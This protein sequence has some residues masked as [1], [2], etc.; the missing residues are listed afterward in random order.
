MFFY[1]VILSFL[2]CTLHV[3]IGQY[4]EETQD[5]EK[6]E[7]VLIQLSKAKSLI[8]T[9]SY[10]EAIKNIE[11]SYYN[12]YN[13][14][15]DKTRVSYAAGL[16]KH[17]EYFA[18]YQ[19]SQA[20]YA[21]SYLKFIQASL[22]RYQNDSTNPDEL[23]ELKTKMI[24]ISKLYNEIITKVI[25]IL[26]NKEYVPPKW[27]VMTSLCVYFVMNTDNENE[28]E[29]KATI[30]AFL[31]ESTSKVFTDTSDNV[32]TCNNKFKYD[33]KWDVSDELEPKLEKLKNSI[34][35]YSAVLPYTG[36]ESVEP[37]AWVLKAMV[38][39][40]QY[41]K[42]LM[43]TEVGVEWEDLETRLK[44]IYKL[45]ANADKM[46]VNNWIIN[47]YDN[48]WSANNPQNFTI[49]VFRI[50]VLRHVLIGI[51]H[52]DN[53]LDQA[54]NA[55]DHKEKLLQLAEEYCAPIGTAVD[56]AISLLGGD[57][58]LKEIAPSLKNFIVDRE[59]VSNIIIKTM[60]KLNE[61]SGML[62]VMAFNSVT[63][64]FEDMA[65][66]DETKIDSKSIFVWI[67]ENNEAIVKYL[68][69]IKENLPKVNFQTVNIFQRSFYNNWIESM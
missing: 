62:R 31:S 61:L 34:E 40:Q 46:A 13:T 23:T 26:I 63:P 37:D 50:V 24:R 18:H 52:C 19:C 44:L 69:N 4:E 56:N 48:F 39:D 1:P 36:S 47:S 57:S 7:K 25:A 9:K 33:T 20:T 22:N 28:M 49:N 5:L 12:D 38:T 21:F 54:D 11:D 10:S 35:E 41:L 67:K 3:T 6:L 42:T 16:M 29:T 51:T 65:L 32:T 17:H 53:M 55:L 60:A 27:L 59:E 58:F 8:L 66:L 68:N 64:Q 15:L 45:E 30:K 14:D 43:S 2:L